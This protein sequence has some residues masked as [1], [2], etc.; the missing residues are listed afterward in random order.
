MLAR[1]GATLAAL[2]TAVHLVWAEQLRVVSIGGSVTEIIYA[3]G[4][5]SRLVGVDTS[6]VFPAA[7]T[8][9]P[10]VG[11][12][13][14]LGAEG[15]LSLKPTLILATA[16]AGPPATMAQLQQ[17]GVRVVIVP[18]D[19]SLT[20]AQEKIRATA[21][22]LDCAAR[23]EE[24]AKQLD[25]P[26]VMFVLARA[27]GVLSVAG[28]GTAADA[29]ITLAGGVNA[30]RGYSGY[31][32]LTAEAAVAAA[33]DVILTTTRALESVGGAEKLVAEP[34]LALT[35]AG[36]NRRVV[37]LEDLYLL[38]FGPRT[39]QAVR[40]LAVRLQEPESAR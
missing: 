13:R 27:G 20:G 4:Q 34:G 23:G 2:V 14:Q 1:L 40:E 35:P 28:E 22:A 5:E 15:V 9:L 10:Q 17:S 38:G 31:K 18:N 21:R 37:A 36:K 3:L 33:P 11:Y 24:L 39:R 26:R 30:V 25:P 6:S 8:K 12:Q 32:P 19:H 29:M 7:A 16:D